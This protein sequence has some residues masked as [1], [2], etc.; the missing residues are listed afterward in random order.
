MKPELKI[1]VTGKQRGQPDPTVGSLSTTAVICN[2]LH[3]SKLHLRTA[4]RSFQ[5]EMHAQLRHTVSPYRRDGSLDYPGPV[6][7]TD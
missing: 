3:I 2:C 4:S 5:V 7:N 6:P 1:V